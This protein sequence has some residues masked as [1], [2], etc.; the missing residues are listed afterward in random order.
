MNGDRI[1]VPRDMEARSA[2]AGGSHVG[3][4]PLVSIIVPCFNGEDYVGDAIASALGQT[5]AGIEVIVVDDAS[6]DGSPDVI[7]SAAALDPRLIPIFL[8]ENAGPAAARNAA[9]TAARGE[10]V[11][12]LDADDLYRSD[13]IERLLALARLTEADVVVDNQYVR[14]FPDGDGTTLAFDFLRGSL[15]VPI[16]QDLFFE[17]ASVF[18]TMNPGYLKPMFRRQ[19][20]EREGLRYRTEYRVGEDFY[21]YAECLCRSASFYGID[22]A[23]YIYRRRETSLTRSGGWPLRK[24][25]EMSGEILAEYGPRLT[26]AARLALERRRRALDRYARLAD[27]RTSSGG[28]GMRTLARIAASPDLLLLAPGIL[29]RKLGG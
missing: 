17:Q 19:F 15:P 1:A 5:Y 7:R 18:G 11:T 25:A 10:W 26:P 29:R 9:L 20:L 27:I 24:L 2:A 28:G 6:T 8:R 21:L 23:G 4:P 14:D 3:P 22:Y 16:S 13:R 12:L